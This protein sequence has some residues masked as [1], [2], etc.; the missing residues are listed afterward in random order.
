MRV[1]LVI[2]AGFALA[3]F[4]Y[5]WLERLG[6]RSVVPLVC[7]AVAWSALGLLLIN[8]G[9]PITDPPGRPLVLLDGSLSMGAAG[10]RW[11]EA[12]DSALALGEVRIFGDERSGTDTVPTRGRSVLGPAL[13][14]AAASG[15]PVV[16]LTDGEIE[17]AG[18]LAP[19][20]LARTRVR[21]YERAPMPDLAITTV[22]GPARIAAGD[23]LAL[24]AEVRALAG[25]TAESVT[26]TLEWGDR[27]LARRI[28]ALGPDRSARV[29]LGAGSAGL[30]AGTHMLR[31]TIPGGDPEA[32]TDVRLHA[33]TVVPTPGVVL[34]AAPA[35]WDSRF[36]Y[37]AVKDV[38]Q[39]P[40]RA[41]ARIEP[42]RWRSLRDLAVVG[43]EQVRQA[44]RRADLLV[45]KGAPPA[46]LENLRA[47]GIWRWPS[48][49]S[50]WTP[51]VV[52]DWY[53]QAGS[54]SPLDGAFAGAPL[55][56]FA[57][58]V[59]M[60]IHRAAPDEWV[61]LT[62]RNGRRGPEWPAIVG[63]DAGRLREVTVL[64]DGLW[65][66]AFRGGASEQTYRAWVAGTVSWLLAGADS[67]QGVARPV[68]AV[69]QNGRTIVFEWIGGG[70]PKATPVVWTG[71]PPGTADTLRFDGAGRAAVRLPP[72]VYG[73]RLT[74]S[75]SGRVGVEAYS[76][77]LLPRPPAL[78]PRDPQ[79]AMR[80]SQR[81]S[82]DFPWLF[83]VTVLAL[84]GE[85]VA[86]RQM[87][88][89]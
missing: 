57:P 51:P 12:R 56:S 65:R 68:R 30:P 73:F 6:R 61:A 81:S 5:L 31:V 72:G 14:A 50:E 63:R 70:A 79:A 53:L 49:E 29:R 16:V 47:R 28:L 20:L 33:I 64:A 36:L 83:L 62:G 1:F 24:D 27:R 46:G 85:W 45:L 17:D 3:A 21:V 77:E 43:D 42:G 11:R 26:V 9:C 86:R 44:A 38:A 48:G 13:A 55:D 25:A 78:A 2:A 4:T 60:T 67:A 34:V 75:G 19:D 84:T 41:Y 18:D 88:L 10:G 71:A 59:Q 89:R 52:G 74:P 35:D 66:W 76:D 40:V 80:R 69:V 22:S 58:A 8:L 39:L 7:R 15:R 37:D 23:S 54:A 87:G 32:R 82:R